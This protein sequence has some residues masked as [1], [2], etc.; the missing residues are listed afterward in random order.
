MKFENKEVESMYY[1]LRREYGIISVS[2][3]EL[4]TYDTI[5]TLK[6]YLKNLFDE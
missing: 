4:I 1:N 6:E 3:D 2:T 5:N